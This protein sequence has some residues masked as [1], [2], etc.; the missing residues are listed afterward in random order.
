M[1]GIGNDFRADDGAGLEVVRA[2]ARDG[3]AAGVQVRELQ[4]EALGLLDMWTEADAVILV[5]T[6]RSGAEPG[7]VHRLDASSGRLPAR[8][9]RTSSHTVSLSE[10]IELAR[11]LGRLPPIVIVFGIE[12]SHFDTGSPLSD[13]VRIGCE[14]ALAAVS[15]EG[16]ALAGQEPGRAPCSARPE[17]GS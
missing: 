15:A 17:P 13:A 6:I 1:V 7:T 5:D 12:G 16:S 3:P 2:L 4:G 14:L 11:S 8:L 10:A 9:A